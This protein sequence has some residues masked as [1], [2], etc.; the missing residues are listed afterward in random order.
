MNP[1]RISESRSYLKEV[2]ELYGKVL[3]FDSVGLLNDYS[4][5]GSGSN[6]Y[7]DEDVEGVVE[8]FSRIF[9]LPQ[10]T[11]SA[12]KEALST[13]AID[14][15][16]LPQED[17]E[18]LM[19]AFPGEETPADI[20]SLLYIM[21]RPYFKAIGRAID[22]DNIYWEEGRCPVCNAAPALSVLAA[23]EAR[24]YCCS[25]CGTAGRYKRIGCPYCGNEKAETIEIMYSEKDEGVRVDACTRCHSY[26]KTVDASMLSEYT[27]EELDLISLPFDIIAQDKG[28]MRRA[29]NPVGIIRVN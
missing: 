23:N 24:R 11:A 25:F 3:K 9:L 12:I 5:I 19:A 27:A 17:F 1:E 22:A 28:F 2:S 29:P 6:C 20:L 10:G 8:E 21:S 4:G 13:G 14:F 26:V 15:T 18:A 7:V 16:M